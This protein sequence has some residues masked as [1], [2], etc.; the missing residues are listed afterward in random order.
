MTVGTVS[1]LRYDPETDAKPVYKQYEFP[2]RQGMTV[3]DVVFYVYEHIDSSLGFSYCCRNSHCGLCG[4]VINDKP[5]LMCRESA[6][7]QMVLEPLGNMAVIRD[8][9]VDRDEY[10]SRKNNLRLFLDRSGEPDMLPEQVA[11][12]VS[13]RFKIASRCVECYCCVASCPVLKNNRHGFLGPA[14]FVQ[15]ARHA[16]DPR[17]NLNREIIAQ[18][19]GINNCTAC[20]RCSQVCPHKI[21][22]AEI[23]RLLQQKR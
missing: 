15:L 18:S 5:G 19:G 23:I 21:D 7:E 6:T 3:L 12:A 20:G 13:E 4:V 8:L 16:F 14:G 17:D 22:P 10:D 11:P 9:I 2:F 1:I